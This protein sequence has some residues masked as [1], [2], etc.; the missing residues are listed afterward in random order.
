MQ[1]ITLDI[2][3]SLYYAKKKKKNYI[4]CLQTHLENLYFSDSLPDY[5][6]HS[7]T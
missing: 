7:M 4:K 2:W 6:L 5:L 3:E 1:I